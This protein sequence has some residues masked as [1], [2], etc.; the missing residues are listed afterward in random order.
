MST[1]I[2][3]NG[4]EIE[5]AGKKLEVIISHGKTTVFLDGEEV[6]VNEDSPGDQP[7]NQARINQEQ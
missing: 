7:E 5:T 4:R 3:V 1:K 2:I 6:K